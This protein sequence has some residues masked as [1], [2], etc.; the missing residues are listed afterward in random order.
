M[1]DDHR[2]DDRRNGD[3]VLA[4][5]VADLIE[6]IRDVP[7]IRG[8]VSEI[9]DVLDGPEQN[10]LDGSV[11]REGGM[12]DKMDILF[13]DSQNGGIKARIGLW[14]RLF[15]ALVGAGGAIIGALIVA[16]SVG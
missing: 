16:A 15:V 14:E 6:Q 12:R 9:I 4:E 3:R 2:T 1:T 5:Q 8:Q 13:D 7:V 11:Y 10:K